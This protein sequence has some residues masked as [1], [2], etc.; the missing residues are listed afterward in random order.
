MYRDSVQLEE[1]NTG[2]RE[3]HGVPKE[4]AKSLGQSLIGRAVTLWA[5]G[6]LSIKQESQTKVVPSSDAQERDKGQGEQWRE[7]NRQTEEHRE[8]YRV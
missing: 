1:P 7:V 2:V 8:S 3:R 6:P 5:C 4:L